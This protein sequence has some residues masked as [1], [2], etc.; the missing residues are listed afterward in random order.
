M[1]HFLSLQKRSKNGTIGEEDFFENVRDKIQEGPS[2]F[3]L[4]AALS[5][6]FI[7]FASFMSIS[8]PFVL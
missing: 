1:M 5:Y 4:P 2:D 7:S 3:L 8:S 6:Y